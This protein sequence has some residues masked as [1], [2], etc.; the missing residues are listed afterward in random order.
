MPALGLTDINVVT[1]HDEQNIQAT[2]VK[3]EHLTHYALTPEWD[4]I[5]EREG[6]AVVGLAPKAA[7]VAEAAAA[8]SAVSPRAA[9]ALPLDGAGVL[10]APAPSPDLTATEEIAAHMKRQTEVSGVS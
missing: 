7:A 2:A 8:E 5:A 9:D 3:R 6:L 1:V 10:L 4:A